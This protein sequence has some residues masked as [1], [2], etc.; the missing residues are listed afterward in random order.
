MEKGLKCYLIFVK[1]TTEEPGRKGIIYKEEQ[2]EIFSKCNAMEDGHQP[3]ELG[4]EGL[5]E[6]FEG[7]L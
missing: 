7:L 4:V 5:H 1:D 2:L 3:T 6:F